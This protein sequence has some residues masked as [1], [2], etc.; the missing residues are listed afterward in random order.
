LDNINRDMLENGLLRQYADEYSITGLTSNPTIFERAIRSSNLY[1]KQIECLLQ[2][3]IVDEQLLFDL[4]LSDLRRAAE[5]FLPR[6]HQTDG[7]DGFVSLE[8]SPFLADDFQGSAAEAQKLHARAGIS[9]LFIKIPGT[10]S[11]LI[12]I[13]ESIARGIPINVTLLFS[14]DQYLGSAEAY[15][16]G[17]ERRLE[18]G[19]S[20]DVP[21]VASIF[22]SRWDHAVHDSVSPSHRNQLGLAIAKEALSGYRKSMCSD[23][24][25]RLAANGARPQRLL[26]ASTGVKDDNLPGDYYA[27]AL[28]QPNTINTLPA[29]TLRVFHER[30]RELSERSTCELD[31]EHVFGAHAAHGIDIQSLAARLQ[32]QGVLAFEDAWRTLLSTLQANGRAMLETQSF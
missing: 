6:Y 19:L 11:G 4:M 1:D 17:L 28:V 32:R 10:E 31:I 29:S 5:I 15:M 18:Q 9:N 24:W 7:V 27:S 30:D 3:A 20:L 21:S 8:I 22:V 25:Q 16:R 23:R 13:E 2:D 26:F 12:A 14:P